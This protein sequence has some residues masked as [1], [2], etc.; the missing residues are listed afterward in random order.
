MEFREGVDLF[1]EEGLAA[2]FGRC[3]HRTASPCDVEKYSLVLVGKPG[4]R[5]L[6]VCVIKARGS[7]TMVAMIAM[8]AM[9]AISEMV[10]MMIAM[11]PRCS[12]SDITCHQFWKCLIA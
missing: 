1:S 9:V 7:N 2:T 3:W 10:A 5:M 6:W 12:A 8:V 4:T 11:S